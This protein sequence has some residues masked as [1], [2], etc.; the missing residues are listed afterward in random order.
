MSTKHLTLCTLCSREVAAVLNWARWQSGQ[1]PEWRV[2]RHRS[3]E[4]P[5]P[6]GTRET[7]CPGTGILVDEVAVF[8]AEAVSA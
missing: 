8:S 7:I 5:A 3:T 1:S 2:H 4:K 6:R